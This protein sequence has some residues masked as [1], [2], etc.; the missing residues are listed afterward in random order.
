MGHGGNDDE[1]E[2]DEDDNDD[3]DDE[4]EREGDDRS[5]ENNNQQ[6]KAWRWSRG[7]P[8][9]ENLTK[10]TMQV[11]EAHRHD[12]DLLLKAPTFSI[13]SRWY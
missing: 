6:R 10:K 8:L 4:E 12:S 7:I 9:T 1:G 2:N 3:D 13:V 5:V 11:G